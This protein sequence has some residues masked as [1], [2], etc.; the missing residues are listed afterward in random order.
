MLPEHEIGV[1]SDEQLRVSTEGD[2]WSLEGVGYGVVSF[3]G[4][5]T[6]ITIIVEGLYTVLFCVCGI[7]G[8][9]ILL[10]SVYII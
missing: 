9:G 8:Y 5:T 4:N 1:W 6:L 2:V 7:M 3:M 10:E